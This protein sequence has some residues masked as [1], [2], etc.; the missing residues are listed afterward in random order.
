[1]SKLAAIPAL[2]VFI[3]GIALALPSEANIGIMIIESIDNAL[4]NAQNTDNVACEQMWMYIWTIRIIGIL[5]I[6]GDIIYIGIQF[7]DGNFL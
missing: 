6:V 4:C 3:L 5:M 2:I 1:M 7:R